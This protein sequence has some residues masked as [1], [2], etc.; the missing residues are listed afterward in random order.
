M[1]LGEHR[2]RTPRGEIELTELEV[3][4]LRELFANEDRLLSRTDLLASVW[5]LPADSETRTLDNFVVRMRKYFEPDP[6]HPVHL[7]TV[8]G[9]G[10]RF[11]RGGGES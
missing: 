8:R 9:R 2:A 11:V 1:W 10:Y 6:S 7:I 5:E 3:R 4:F